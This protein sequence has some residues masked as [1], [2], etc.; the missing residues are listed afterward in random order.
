METAEKFRQVVSWSGKSKYEFSKM[1]GLERPDNLYNVLNGKVPN[2]GEDLIRRI[3]MAFPKINS[4]FLL[5]VGDEIEEAETQDEIKRLRRENQL[6]S[7]ALESKG[8]VLGKF[9]GA[10]VQPELADHEGASEML[11]DI[12][13]WNIFGSQV[14]SHSVGI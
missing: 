11:T 3:K 12:A 5:G 10:T 2:P 7:M 4:D 9:K 6:L 8:V 13:F 1:I 14:G